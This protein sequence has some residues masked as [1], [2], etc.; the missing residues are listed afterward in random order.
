VVQSGRRTELSTAGYDRL[1]RGT[2]RHRVRHSVGPADILI[3]EGVPALLDAELVALAQ[4]KVYVAA[5]APTRS[6]RLYADYAWRGVPP[7]EVDGLMASRSLD[8]HPEVAAAAA[9]ADYLISSEPA[10]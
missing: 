9:S 5:T 1:T 7:A 2:H 10:L 4:V 8:E 6:A 3:V